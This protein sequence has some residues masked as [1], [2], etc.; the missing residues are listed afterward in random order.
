MWEIIPS[1][2]NLENNQEPQ[3]TN[4][5][6]IAERKTIQTGTERR[7]CHGDTWDAWSWDKCRN[8]KRKRDLWSSGLSFKGGLISS[9]ILPQIYPLRP[10]TCV[11]WC[12]CS[13][14]PLPSWGNQ[15][16]IYGGHMFISKKVGI[17]T[18][19]QKCVQ[20][21]LPFRVMDMQLRSS[22]RNEGHIP[23]VAGISAG[24]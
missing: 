9:S 21:W 1:D 3:F 18:P 23:P 2:A 19:L 14:P 7:Q 5:E 8:M 22:A 15:S 12:H 11:Q 20:N 17:Q 6:Q 10:H 16:S 13:R 4:L 24:R